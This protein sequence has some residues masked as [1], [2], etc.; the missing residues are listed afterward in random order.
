M[1]DK[2]TWCGHLEEA[3]AEL[4]AL[5][6]PW[7]DRLTLERILRV[8]RRRAQ[9]ILQPCVKQQVGATGVADREELIAHLRE[10]ANGQFVYYERRRRERLAKTIQDLNQA[11][12]SQPK[13]LVEAP[14]AIVNQELS[15]LPPGV[16]LA[17]GKLIVEF[18]TAAEA[19][20]K[21]LAIAMAAGND[22]DGYERLVDT[23]NAR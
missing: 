20:E 6:Y 22:L 4:R 13:T 9:Q 23:S 17:P 21:L 2:P 3:I 14:T 11:W 18:S 19:L 1:P 8:R 10:L 15:D 16:T 12:K 5:P 7:V